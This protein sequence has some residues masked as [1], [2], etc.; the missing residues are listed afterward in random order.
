MSTPNRDGLP[1]EVTDSAAAVWA[2]L[3]SIAGGSRAVTGATGREQA[4]WCRG[5]K[6]EPVPVRETTTVRELLDIGWLIPGPVRDY[7]YHGTPLVGRLLLFTRCA[8]DWAHRRNPD[9]WFTHHSAFEDT[10]G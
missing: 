7:D 10:D 1:E 5:I 8:R 4:W 9:W 3:D 2:L 6:A